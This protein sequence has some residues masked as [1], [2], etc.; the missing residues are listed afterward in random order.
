MHGANRGIGMEL[1]KLNM[2]KLQKYQNLRLAGVELTPSMLPRLSRSMEP[3]DSQPH[4][5]R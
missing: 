4:G 5:H 1:V 2:F 3:G